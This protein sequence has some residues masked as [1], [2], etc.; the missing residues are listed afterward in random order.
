MIL[1]TLKG[2]RC[3]ITGGSRGI[4][5]AIAQLFASQGAA[6]SLIARNH[7]DLGTAVKSLT[8]PSENET[9]PPVHTIHSMDGSSRHYWEDLLNNHFQESPIDIL[10]NAAGVSQNSLLPR[11]PPEI[12]TE[13]LDTNL[14]ATIYGCQAILPRMQRQKSG[15]IINISSALATHGGRGATVYAASKA[16]VVALTRSMALE[17]ARFGIRANVILPGYINTQMTKGLS[18]QDIASQIPL[19]RLGEPE[20]VAHAAA[21]LV[22][23]PYAHNC[24]LNLDGGLSAN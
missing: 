9:N 17:T 6:C 18:K 14:K 16:G 11:T 15:C 8:P 22:N 12:V 5:L 3:L 24:V 10:V 4:G 19:G 2:K 21:F 1:N 20:E 7:N 13:I 23:N